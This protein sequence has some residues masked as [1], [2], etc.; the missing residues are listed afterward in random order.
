MSFLYSN[1]QDA[2]SHPILT[3]AP[4]SNMPTLKILLIFFYLWG[5]SA[6]NLDVL[7]M[8]ILTTIKENSGTW[9]NTSFTLLWR[10]TPA[11]LDATFARF[12]P[13]L[14]LNASSTPECP[15]KN[16][17]PL[18]TRGK[19]TPNSTAVHYRNWRLSHQL[20][21]GYACYEFNQLLSNTSLQSALPG[22]W[23][24]AP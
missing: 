6:P 5:K 9:Q 2:T 12:A 24:P 20:F 13:P 10:L 19:E 14:P 21:L 23:P 15:S 4:F 7:I 1:G 16:P 3:S 8:L 17:S 11:T 18:P 22:P